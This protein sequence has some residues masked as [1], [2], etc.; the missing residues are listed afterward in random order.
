MSNLVSHLRAHLDRELSNAISSDLSSTLR[1]FFSGPPREILAKLFANLTCDGRP[2][3]IAMDDEKIEIPVYLLDQKV[4]DP[5]DVPQAARCTES[6]FVG[7]IRNNGSIPFCLALHECSSSIQSVDSTVT[8]LGISRDLVDLNSWMDSPLVRGLLKDRVDELIGAA[9]R[10]DAYRAIKHALE[11]AWETDERYRDKRTAWRVLEK[12]FDCDVE[13]REPHLRI[14]SILGLPSCESAVFG[15]K[16]HLATLERMKDFFQSRGLRNGFEELEASAGDDLISHVR[17]FRGHVEKQGVLDAGQLAGSPLQMYCPFNTSPSAIPDWWRALSVEAWS[18][19]LD[20]GSEVETSG[21]LVV[22]IVNS[23]AVVPRGI[24]TVVRDGV[25]FQIQ[26]SD[27][28][29]HVEVAISRASGN[30]AL[31]EICRIDVAPNTVVPFADH[32]LPQHARFVRYKLEAD[33]AAPVTMKVIALEKYSVGLVAVCREAKKGT[34]FA[35]NKRA[36]DDRGRR[37]ERYECDLHLSGMGSHQLDLFTGSTIGLSRTMLGYE[38]DAEHADVIERPINPIDDAHAVCLI[39]TDEQC[40]YDFEVDQVGESNTRLFRIYVIADD[41]EPSGASSEFD[42]LVITHRAAARR[43]QPNACVEPLACRAANLEEWLLEDDDSYLPIVLGPDYLDSWRRPAWS[44]R[45]VLSAHELPVDPRPA[46]AEFRAPASFVEARKRVFEYLRTPS[47]EPTP[48]AGTLQ[49]HEFMR[50]SEFVDALRDLLLSYHDWLDSSYEDAAWADVIAIHGRQPNADA[51]ESQPYAILLT[52]YHPVRLAWQCRAQYVLQDAIGKNARCPAASMLNPSCFPDCFLLPCRS[53]TGHIKRQ[54]FAAMATTSDYWSVVWST[55][56]IARLSD[57]KNPDRMFGD[58]LGI[59]IDG[60]SSGFSAQQVIRALDE[61]SKLMSARSVLR[62]GV[63]SDSAGSGSCN[64]GLDWWCSDNLGSDR[65]DWHDSGP[66]GVRVADERDPEL[67]PEQAALASLTSR[68]SGSVSWFSKTGEREDGKQDLS[69]IAHLGTV[70]NDFEP[71]GIRSAIDRSALIRWRVRKQL[72]SQNDAFIAESRV[73]EIPKNI[74][75]DPIT[76][77]ML[78]CVD[79]IE[80]KC[81]DRIDSYVFAPN[82]TTLRTVVDRSWYTAVSSSNV[83]AACFFGSTA[84]AYMWDYELPAYS[85]R[86]GGNSGYF[87]LAKESEGMHLAIRR[88][89]DQLGDS[90]AIADADISAMLREVSRRGM[91]T[92]KRLTT[93]GSMSLGEIGML[94]GL[95]FLQSDFETS[96]LRPALLPVIEPGKT[97]NLVVPAD[98]FKNQFEDLRFALEKRQGERPDLLVMSIGFQSGTPD[99]IRITPIEV[100]ARGGKMSKTD[101]I[102]ALSQASSFG[103]FLVRAQAEAGNSELWAIAWRSLIS[104][105]LDYGFRVYG[106]LEQFIQHEEWSRLHSDVLQA[107]AKGDLRVDVEARGRLVVIDATNSTSQL[108]LDGDDFLETVVMSHKDALSLLAGDCQPFVRSARSRLEDWQ[109][110]PIEEAAA[111]VVP[112]EV[113]NSDLRSDAPVDSERMSAA[114]PN[115][116]SNGPDVSSDST[117]FPPVTAAIDSSALSATDCG[118]END[119][120]NGD[121]AADHALCFSVGRTIRGFCEEEASFFP[122]NTALNQLNVGVVGDLGTG[123]TQLVQSLIYQLR[124]N[125]EKNRGVR[126]NVL[127]FDYKKD[128][129]KTDFVEATGARVVSPFDI[130]LNL[131]D[132][133]DSR[134]G[135]NVWLERAKFFSDVLDKIYPGIGPTQRVRIKSAVKEAYEATGSLGGGCPTISDVF[136]AYSESAGGKIDSP[137]SIMSD[138]VDGGYFV[139][140]GDAVKPFSEFLDGIV[141]LDLAEVGQ[142]DRTKNMLVVIFLNL[143]YEHMLRIEKRDFLGSD[144]RLRFVDTM[145]LV[146]EADNIMRYEFDVLK[147]ILLQGREFGVGVLLASQY[148]SHFTTSHEN[149][150]E[151]LLTWFVHKVPNLRVKDLEAIGLIDVDGDLV[152]AVK[153]LNCHECLFKTLGFDGKII[154]A[155]PFFELL[156]SSP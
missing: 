152:D 105:L 116:G 6:Y 97:L 33:G 17:A 38:V 118:G 53:A 85:R 111:A 57:A 94:V 16:E 76:G 72:S 103:G 66:R 89:I 60:L 113:M 27:C 56:S 101:Q 77:A 73:G 75:V 147:K 64:E 42:R 19:L 26:I 87:L 115:S 129:S 40:H 132:T 133:R 109:L 3:E 130:P 145:I 62:V 79:S 58:E 32:D 1:V 141:V 46:S 55:D 18:K 139:K 8:R 112:S 54:P 11:E 31:Q 122:G 12:I 148:L 24:P 14:S 88:A 4:S 28:E 43:E 155:T 144:P 67:Q 117:P 93:G 61:V 110:M 71:Q 7:A 20:A 149:Y 45:P 25:E 83:D 98:P 156:R 82:M 35:L 63:T 135:R 47:G 119:V 41:V 153:S 68:T 107:L 127:I 69:I 23:V 121:E 106:Q 128:Y 44:E 52:P 48:V 125:P 92:L 146:D 102:A 50:D 84:N 65:D 70:S 120:T 22:A 15:G 2:L 91:P 13:E 138:L 39:E 95:R 126:P 78:A 59:S 99:R 123:K 142:D 36:K 51:L 37:V 81:R 143:F 140:D 137:Y 74:D 131:F 150:F 34:P 49:L 104:T 96:G 134:H 86:A 136:S 154:R 80:R 30:A 114:D 29:E 151:P 5:I 108:D 10:D 90:S 100:K 124:A 21:K 9:A